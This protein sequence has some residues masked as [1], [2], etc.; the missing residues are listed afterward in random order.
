MADDGYAQTGHRDLGLIF[1]Q[2]A[3]ITG[4]GV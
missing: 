1:R 3:T 4:H 2:P